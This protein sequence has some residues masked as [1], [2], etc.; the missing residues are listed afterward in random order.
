MNQRYREHDVARLLPEQPKQ[1]ALPGV[2]GEQRSPFAR[3][4][5]RVL[6]SAALRRLA[7]KTQVVGP[8]EGD[9]PRTRLTHSLEV[10]QI[11]RGIGAELGC[12]PD[13][14]DTAG[15]AHD[16]GHPPFGHNGEQALN[17]LAASCGGFE[18]NAQTLRIL[19]RL[20]PK[21]IDAEQRV[22]GLNLTRASLDATVKYP[23]PRRAGQ[24]KFGVYAEDQAVFDWVRDG[25]P[26]SGAGSSPGEADPPR[27]LEAQV[28][29]WADDVAYSVHD[30]EDGVVAGRISLRVLT[31]AVERRA[32]AE[33]AAANFSVDGV[34]ELE[35]AAARLARL[36]VVADVLEY[37]GGLRAQVAL[38]RLTSELVGRFAS[39]A[40]AGTRHK[41]GP[42]PLVRYAAELV[43]PAEVAAEVA[44]LKSLAVRY[45][46]SDPRRLAAQAGQRELLAE[47][48]GALL[49]R[50]PDALDPAFL[51]AWLRA[52]DDT[53]RLRVVIDQV[54][55]LT[56][57]QARRW[58]GELVP[59]RGSGG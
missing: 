29:D 55:C 44:V 5:A 57:A 22:A 4:R 40:I 25:A 16:I 20:E 2:H 3:D 31:D 42:G 7:G 12:D 26:V 14:V 45:V 48:V 9:V 37:D 24:R 39:A 34:A 56:D 38:K 41:F 27:C 21:S 19:T 49:D 30:V 52:P 47:L 54:A 36:P 6:H 50:A 53:G 17:E 10:A 43:V 28:M 35:T 18:G 15:L 13:V 11:G 33:L 46:M 51:P 58:H 32:L 23:W 1:A 59:R 8:D